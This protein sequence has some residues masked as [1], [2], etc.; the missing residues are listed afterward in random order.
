MTTKK[1]NTKTVRVSEAQYQVMRRDKKMKR[2]IKL[3]VREMGEITK[4]WR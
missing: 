3:L 4:N 2:R 1:K